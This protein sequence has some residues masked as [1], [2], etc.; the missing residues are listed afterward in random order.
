MEKEEKKV[1][2]CAEGECT[3]GDDCK[4]D[5]NCSCGCN[6]PL[7]IE[8]EDDNGKKVKAQIVGTFDDNG[9]SYAIVNDLDNEDNSYLFEVQSTENGDMLVSVDDEKEFDRLC[10]VV[11]KLISENTE[12]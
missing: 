2:N 3:C 1:C 9:K 7:I 10:T 5:E 6:N 8:L 11:D 4:C 12:K